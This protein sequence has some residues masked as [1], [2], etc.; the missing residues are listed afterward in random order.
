M[1]LQSRQHFRHLRTRIFKYKKD[2]TGA[3]KRVL[4]Y[5]CMCVLNLAFPGALNSS[6]VTVHKLLYHIYDDAGGICQVTGFHGL[7]IF[8]F[9]VVYFTYGLEQ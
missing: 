4:P 3:P 5:F 1:M 6:V 7:N 9:V 2:N 8:I